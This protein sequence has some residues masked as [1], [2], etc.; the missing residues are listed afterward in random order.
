MRWLLI[1]LLLLISH[2]L[3]LRWAYMPSSSTLTR[4]L[5]P[6]QRTSLHQVCHDCACPRFCSQQNTTM[7]AIELTDGVLARWTSTTHKSSKT[8]SFSLQHYNYRHHCK[9]TD[10]V[11]LVNL[12]ACMYV[13]NSRWHKTCVSVGVADGTVRGI[14]KL[15]STGAD[16]DTGTDTSA[17]DN[18]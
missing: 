10:S 7:C 13:W 4:N 17:I 5:L 15:L 18:T 11:E 8:V 6:R 16:T 12:I 14:K 2:G 3:N 1:K 9:A